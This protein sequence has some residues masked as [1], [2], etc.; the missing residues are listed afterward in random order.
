VQLS[1]KAKVEAV[2]SI[3]LTAWFFLQKSRFG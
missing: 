1:K 2:A 3:Y